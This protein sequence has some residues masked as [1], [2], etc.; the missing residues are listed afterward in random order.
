VIRQV[1]QYHGASLARLVRADESPAILLRVHDE[2]R[3]A[4]TLDEHVAL[5]VKYSTSRLSPWAFR[6]NVEHQEEIAM[7]RDEFDE[8]F[9]TLVCGSDGIVCLSGSEYQRVLDDDPKAG[10][11]IKVARAP[12]EKYA[13]SGSDDRSIFRI[14]DNEF[15]AKVYAAIRRASGVGTASR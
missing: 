15:P 1:E 7:L 5:Y 8:A 13:I 11:W 9:V 10:E 12:R 6:F 2:C 14:G 4:Y 3:S